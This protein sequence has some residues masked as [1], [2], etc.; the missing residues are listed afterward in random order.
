MSGHVSVK[1]DA[2]AFGMVLLELLTGMTPVGTAQLY[3]M[4]DNCF[5]HMEQK[6]V[7]RNSGRWPRGV[8]KK[9]TQVAEEC[10]AW[11]SNKRAT[12]VQV[13]PKLLKVCKS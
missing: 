8:V 5:T 7:D 9:V 4:D 1:T 12:V 2:F 10:L 3:T 13:L 6:F 11:K